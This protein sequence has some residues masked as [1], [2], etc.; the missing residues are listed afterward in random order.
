MHIH[1]IPLTINIARYNQTYLTV[2]SYS[3]N[4]LGSLDILPEEVTFSLGFVATEGVIV[5]I[6]IF[7]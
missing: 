6:F 3:P 2:Q 1:Y 4:L 7:I 5:H